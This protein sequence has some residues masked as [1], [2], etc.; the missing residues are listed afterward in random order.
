MSSQSSFSL[1]SLLEKEKL[2]FNGANFLDWHRNLRLALRFEKKEYLLTTPIPEKEPAKDAPKA[3]KDSYDQHIIDD[4]EIST[5]IIAVMESE[6]QK[7]FMDSG[8]GVFDI[9]TRLKNMFQDKA[10]TER[11]KLIKAIANTRLAEGHE[12]GPHVMKMAG[13]FRQLDRLDTPFSP[14]AVQDFILNSLPPSFTGFIVNYRMH[15]MDKSLD[16]LQNMLVETEENLKREKGAKD[17]L[18]V[19]ERS[20]K[21][22][23]KTRRAKKGKGRV[24][25]QA[26]AKGAPKGSQVKNPATSETE[27]YYCKNKGH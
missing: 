21:N 12:V 1:R 7:E 23:K 26:Q 6:L 9:I 16:E 2:A 8:C 22:K 10:R 17:V 5:L 27:C 20:K 14:G 11:G 13:F 19:S 15:A 3:E 24:T 4:M 25:P 18:A